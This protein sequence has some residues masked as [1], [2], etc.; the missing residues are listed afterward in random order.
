MSRLTILCLFMLFSV[1]L[2]APLSSRTVY[3][4]PIT[5]PTSSTVWKTGEVQTVTWNAT[6]VPAGV[7]GKIM[8]GYFDPNSEGEHLSTTLASGFNLTDEK[9]DITVPAVVTR[10]TYILVLFGDSGNFSPEFT[11]QGSVSSSAAGSN[12]ASP[13]P[14]PV[15]S[16]STSRTITPTPP[17][18][19][20]SFSQFSVPSSTAPTSAPTSLSSS[21][22]APVSADSSNS[23]GSPSPSPST[24]AGWSM[25]KFTTAQ[26]V[27]PPAFAAL[28]LLI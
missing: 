25:N 1:I 28:L 3:A 12:T 16:S 23:F 22:P 9:V 4:P 5:S 2:A 21:L 27:M 26:V 14:Q 24:N 8:L 17:I 18:A 10:T 19:T 13:P 20:G 6:A 11:I 7:T 15:G